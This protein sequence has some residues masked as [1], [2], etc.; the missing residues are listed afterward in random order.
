MARMART[1]RRSGRPGPVW[2]AAPGKAATGVSDLLARFHAEAARSLSARASLLLE[3]DP[4]LRRLTPRWAVG[5]ETLNAAPWRPTAGERRALE[6]LFAGGTARYWGRLAQRWPQLAAYV[7]TRGAILAPLGAPHAVGLLVI[8]TTRAARRAALG[9]AQV[10]ADGLTMALDRQVLRQDLECHRHMHE[11]LLRLWRTAP[12]ATTLASGLE[13]VCQDVA[14]LFEAE[15]TTLWW[16][17]RRAHELVAVASSDAAALATALPVATSDERSLV[18]GA[19]R[20]PR[21][22]LVPAGPGEAG[23]RPVIT[24]PLRGRRRALGTLLIEGVAE[25]AASERLLDHA[26]VLGHLLSST[27]ENLQLFDEV[28]RSRR[29]LDDTFNS[30]ADLIVV[31]DRRLTLVRANQAFAA[32]LGRSPDE[33]RE[34]PLASLVGPETGAWLAS[35]DLSEACAPRQPVTRVLDDRALGGTF[36][37]TVCPLLNHE[38]VTIGV[39]LTARD[40]TEQVRLEAERTAL[41]ERLSHAEKLAALGQFIAGIAHELNNPLQGIL[42]HIEL[43]R[44]TG[45]VPLNLRREFRTIYREA[46]RAAKIVQNL[47][48]FAGSRRLVRRPVRLNALV[49]RA[50]ALR[51]GA[52]R[53]A[54][55]ELVRDYDEGLPRLMGDPLLLQQALLN[56]LINA[57]QAVLSTT[58]PHRIEVTTRYLPEERLA[59]VEIRDTGPGFTPEVL[60]R[61]FEPFFTTKEVGRGTGLGL[62]ITYGIV[63]EHG[64][65]ITA[66]NHPDGGAVLRVQLPADRTVVK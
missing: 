64:G 22:E 30:I 43:L 55:I 27:L 18:A 8:A 6:H 66:T 26:D 45:A 20:R 57:E 40:V 37:M 47:L 42:G 9:L 58:G 5:L 49:S 3:T 11:V 36:S 65:T 50:L 28:L 44:T 53:E 52:W 19:M 24:V 60:P 56:I 51:L 10:L 16:H 33:L 21:A 59:T 41:S 14:R 13:V 31:C 29:E 54:G 15:R 39:V 63:Q 32:R 34:R 2:L 62:A 4:N 12:S 7:P 46:E 61:I 23:L 25:T 38:G 35:L 1:R 17:D 48:V